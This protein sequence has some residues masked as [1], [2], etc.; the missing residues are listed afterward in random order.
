[1]LMAALMVSGHL[2]G[3]SL[4]EKRIEYLEGKKHYPEAA[5][6][7]KAWF[8]SGNPE[9]SAGAGWDYYRSG[10]LKEAEKYFQIADSLGVL[11]NPD[12]V[13]AY[14]ETLKSEKRYDEAQALLRKHSAL[15]PAAD[16]FK[17]NADQIGFYRRIQEFTSSRISRM[18]INSPYSEIGPIVYNGWLY[19]ESTRPTDRNRQLHSI[20]DQPFYNFY[21]STGD[22][23]ETVS[24]QPKGEFGK[25][26]VE[27][28]LNEKKSM[29]LPGGINR[30]F[31]DGPIYVSADGKHLFYTTNFTEGN[32][33]QP[34]MVRLHLYHSQKQDSVWTKPVELPF[35]SSAYS[36]AHA[37][38]DAASGILYFASDMPGGQGGFDI[39]KSE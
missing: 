4:I 34:Q 12:Q 15:H 21:A 8:K 35:S 36:T 20:N 28:E 19:F 9:A 11:N 24:V 13:F 33:K 39:W 30:P 38:F 3:Q 26:E 6:M 22:S 31:H 32:N 37:A 10:N 25:P 23:S 18:A 16:V 17:V 7:Y 1:M 5:R 29:S 2:S 27:L 14:F